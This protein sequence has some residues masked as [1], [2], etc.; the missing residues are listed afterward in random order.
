MLIAETLADL[1]YQAIEAADAASA[2]KVLE[3]DAEIDLLISDVGLPGGMN[4]KQMADSARAKRPKLRVLFITGYAE[5]ATISSGS[6]EPGMHVMSKPFPMEKL[7][8]RI[9]FIMESPSPAG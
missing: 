5:N 6:L 2:L 1:G 4:G 3:S 7:A 8:S 9:R